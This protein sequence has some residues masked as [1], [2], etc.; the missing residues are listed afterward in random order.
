MASAISAI[1]ASSSA[2]AGSTAVT[3]TSPSQEMFLKLLVA[4]I[5]NQDPTNPTESTQFVSQLAQFSELEQIIAIR[6]NLDTQLA[7]STAA[8]QTDVS[9]QA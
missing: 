3:S 4:Q 5:K 6:G 1:T 7:Q 9:T 2:A 8:Q